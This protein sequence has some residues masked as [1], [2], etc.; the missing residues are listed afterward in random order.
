MWTIESAKFE[1]FS[2]FS[3]VV[4][5]GFLGG[6]L[7]DNPCSHPVVILKEVSDRQL[8]ALVHFMYRGELVNVARQDLAALVQIADALQ[9]REMAVL[10]HT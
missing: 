3:R 2:I 5:S 10:F 4:I 7:A 9:V 8:Q 1:I 6:L